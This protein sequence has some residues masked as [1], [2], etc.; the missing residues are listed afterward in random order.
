MIPRWQERRQSAD[1]LPRA[2]LDA[3]EV[4]KAMPKK[5][6]F[7]RGMDPR[8]RFS[9]EKRTGNLQVSHTENARFPAPQRS[10][11]ME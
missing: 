5:G 7:A 2:P 1:A 6:T 8:S 4:T 3:I 9:A 11:G 10:G